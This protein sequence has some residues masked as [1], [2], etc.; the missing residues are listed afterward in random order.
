MHSASKYFLDISKYLSTEF[1]KVSFK[2]A[3]ETFNVSGKMKN[4]SERPGFLDITFFLGSLNFI[5]NV[6]LF[7]SS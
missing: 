6:Q 1:F 3:E 5:K 7:L 2:S 4:L